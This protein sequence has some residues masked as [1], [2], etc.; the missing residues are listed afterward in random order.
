MAAVPELLFSQDGGRG[1]LEHIRKE[2]LDLYNRLHSIDHDAR[3]VDE[4]HKH[5]PSL[6]LI[7]NLRCGAWYTSPSIAMDT[8]AYFKSTDG[9][10][11]NWSFNLRR[12]N[13]HLLPL[14][15][16][17]GGL[18]LVDSTR[19]GKRMPDAL[20]KTVPIWCSVIN[21][22]V[23]KRSPGVYERRDSWDTAL[24]TPLLVV[25]RQ[26]HAQIEEKLDRWAIDLAQS[27]FSLPD[28][29]L[30]LRPVWITPA[31]STFPSLNALQVD[32]LPII[33][34]SASRQVENGVERRGDGFAY[35][36][37]S[38]DDHEL[39]GK[40][41]T[42]AIFWK[43]HREIVAATRD[44]LAP[45]VDRLCAAVPARPGASRTRPSPMATQSLR[46]KG[47]RI[48]LTSSSHKPAGHCPSQPTL[49]STP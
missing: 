31:S 19:A 24:Y 8:P 7:P 6:P 3:F 12:A 46:T 20:S 40:G 10:T 11:N 49:A 13:L 26:E 39:W 43:H 41:L 9:H 32:A 22:A 48:W 17:K 1:I 36:Q 21:R 23:L 4:V 44:E 15:V 5:L 33:C 28:L 14:I 38:G 27:S 18:V 45:L 34:V 16:E 47:R 35:V 42:P 2:N 25:S 37:G 30:P 29:P